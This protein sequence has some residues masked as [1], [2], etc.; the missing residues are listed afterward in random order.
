MYRIFW[1]KN[2]FTFALSILYINNNEKTAI[3][4]L[5]AARGE[6]VMGFRNFFLNFFSKQN[7]GRQLRA[8]YICT[9][10][11][12]L[13]LIGI[14]IY[15]YSYRQ[16][17]QNYEH[18]SELKAR[19][20]RS[21]LMTTT[22]NLQDIYNTLMADDDLADLLAADFSDVED[23]HDRLA[24]YSGFND[25]LASNATLT[26]L[27]IYV[28]ESY[29][30]SGTPVNYFYP[31]TSDVRHSEWYSQSAATRQNFWRTSARTGQLGI[32]YW[33]LTYYCR[34]PIPRKGSYALLVMTVSN[35]HLRSMIT[36]DGYDIYASVSSSP[37]FFC[38]DRSYAG[39]S[40]PIDPD[41]ITAR[42]ETGAMDIFGTKT[43]ASVS[44]L[45]PYATS[46]NIYILAAS[47]DAVSYINHLGLIFFLVI[48]FALIIS[49]LLVFI[50]TRYFSSRIQTLRLGMHKAAH[51]DYEIVNSIQGRDELSAAFRDLKSMVSTLKENEAKIYKSQIKE[52]LLYNQQQQMELKL[53]T[54]QINPHFLYNTL[55]TI[56]MKAFAEGNREVATA[57]K[58]LGKS[59]RYV[60]NN[61][62]SSATTLDK[63]V[64]YVRT[65]L[66][67]QQI[68]FGSRLNYTIR[69]DKGL[70]PVHYQ[71]LPLLIQPI[72]ENA[73]SHGLRDKGENGHIII[74]ISRSGD[75][76]LVTDVFDNGAGMTPEKLQDVILHLD[77]PQPESDHGV[78]LY[79]ISNR[80]HLFYGQEYGLTIRSKSGIGTLVTLVIPLL[81]L[82][83][84]EE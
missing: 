34:I 76:M 17:T 48:L 19:Q 20:V 58:L 68:R 3:C 80:V 40:F 53:L 27:C 56:R 57:I 70:D 6:A 62:K 26:S 67:I 81:N 74:K 79:N 13:I 23:A 66:S 2:T 55:E 31:I 47:R 63:E 32:S 83:E 8:L 71:I 35:D 46:D 78:G 15:G 77:I 42:Q 52:Q 41:T 9:V 5:I 51:N 1:H 14:I 30:H 73:I 10:A 84:E 29:M 36:D 49:S 7:V 25:I 12:P 61:T 22:L 69:I 50:Y 54:S 18:L 33:E 60:L 39:N 21:V 44:A 28:D 16:M 65:Y 43:I 38:T 37:V 75:D 59:M 72:V 82:T 4:I 24:S 45:T 64:D 11:V